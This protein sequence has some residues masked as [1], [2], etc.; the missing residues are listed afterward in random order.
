MA[1]PR[2]VQ[3]ELFVLP[4]GGSIGGRGGAGGRPP[5]IHRTSSGGLSKSEI[6]SALGTGAARG[7][8]SRVVGGASSASGAA[9][10]NLST[11][12]KK[13]LSGAR[14]R[15]PKSKLG[16]A[17]LG[18][19]IAPVA[20]AGAV[21]ALVAM[22]PEQKAAV[23]GRDVPSS[24]P[25]AARASGKKGRALTQEFVSAFVPE[26][27]MPASQ[28]NRLAVTRARAVQQAI[29]HLAQGEGISRERATRRLIR[30]AGG[31]AKTRVVRQDL[32]TSPGVRRLFSGLR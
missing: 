12:A 6:R 32:A 3:K 15:V 13:I 21:G 9:L 25:T 17:G 31:L 26:R 14:P 29:T 22:A 7:G 30:I 10:R 20:A 24:K 28:R 8:P 19:G 27:G 2:G 18:L 1:R 4:G 5:I 23:Q 11:G 16:K